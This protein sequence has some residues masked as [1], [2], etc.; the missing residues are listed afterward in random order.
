MASLSRNQ[1]Y[2][3][4]PSNSSLDYYATNSNTNF[5]TQLP[6]SI[7][8]NGGGNEWEMALVEI[9]YPCSFQTITDND[10]WMRLSILKSGAT[11][12]DNISSGADKYN[13]IKVYLKP[14]DY[15]SVLDLLKEINSNETLK[16]NSVTFEY[17]E[18]VKTVRLRC[19]EKKVEKVK[20]SKTLALILGFDPRQQVSLQNND[21]GVRPA[22]IKLGLPSQ[23]YVYCDLVEPQLVGDTCAPLLRI[24]DIISYNCPYGAYKTIQFQNP[25]YVPIIKSTFQTVEID[26][27]DDTGAQLPF[28]FGNTCVKLHLRR[29]QQQQQ[30][31]Y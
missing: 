7:S 15:G 21:N 2:I 23:M 29:Q 31:Q 30:Q 8:L 13:Q 16:K 24:V 25:H 10:S 5:I 6:S 26:L 20:L 9:H 4:L 11:G 19:A 17:I 27:R 18:K 22:D 14:G 1:F 3:T 12:D 28:R